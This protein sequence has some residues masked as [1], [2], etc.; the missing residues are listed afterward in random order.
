MLRKRHTLSW[1]RKVLKSLIGSCSLILKRPCHL[2]L[3]FRALLSARE[4]IYSTFQDL[5]V[6]W[7][8]TQPR[9]LRVCL[10]RAIDRRFRRS[11]N[12]SYRKNDSNRGQLR[13]RHRNQRLKL[14]Q[15][16]WSQLLQR[17]IRP[18]F[19]WMISRRPIATSKPY[20][21]VYRRVSTQALKTN[22]P[23]KKT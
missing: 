19:C 16:Y 2:S 21:T 3:K 14:P 4:P 5:V 15:R 6:T 7:A 13:N 22:C 1:R 18:L 23:N 17:L 11:W 8:C 12:A 20:S 9:W 10:E